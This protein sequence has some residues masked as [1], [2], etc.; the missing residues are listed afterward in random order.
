VYVFRVFSVWG[1]AAGFEP[2]GYNQRLGM[3][4]VLLELH[5]GFGILNLKKIELLVL[6]TV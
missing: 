5:W 2:I 4:E 6:K 3:L 1:G